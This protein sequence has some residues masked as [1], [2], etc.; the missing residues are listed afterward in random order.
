MDTAVAN[1]AVVFVKLGR[2]GSVREG[3]IGTG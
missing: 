2:K 1:G 3:G